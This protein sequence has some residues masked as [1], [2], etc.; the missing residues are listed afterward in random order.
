MSL[1]GNN[2]R[3]LAIYYC[4][5]HICLKEVYGHRSKEAMLFFRLLLALFAGT[6]ICPAHAQQT[7][8][9]EELALSYGKAASIS[10]ATGSQQT[11][12][13][14]PAVATV[15]TSEDIAAMGA[16]DLD[17]VLETVPGIH[18]N[19]SANNYSPLYVVRG[20]FSQ[21]SPQVLVL[22]NGLPITTLYQG[23]KGN[24]WGGYP[25]E[26]IARIEIIR[27][28]GSALYGSDAF[29]G[30]INIITKSAAE[31]AGTDIGV[32][33]GSFA[34]RDAWIQHGSSIG[35]TKVAAYLRIGQTAG[36]R[37]II[38]ADA[39]SRND[40]LFGTKVSLAPGP[41]NVGREAVDAGLDVRRGQWEA[42]LGYKLRD[43]LGTGAGIASALDPTGK[44]RSE[45]I[46][47]SLSWSDHH[48]I[49]D[50]SA[51]F[52]VSTLQYKQQIPV[53]FRLLPPGATLP[54]GTFQDGM[55]A[56][57]DTWER[58]VRVSAFAEHT[59]VSKHVIRFGVGHEDMNM[60]RTRETRNF[61]YT[62]SGTPIP[63]AAVVD[64]SES[65]PFLFPHR[66]KLDFLYVQD[67]WDIAQDWTL[68]SGVRRDRYSDF[69]ATTNPRIALVWDAAVDITAKLMFGRAFRAPSYIE[70]YGITNPVAIGN[71]NLVPEKIGTLESSVSWHPRYDTQLNLSMYRY[72]MKDIIRTVP[73]AVPG[74]GATYANT[75]GQ[76]GYGFELEGAWA[77]TR[78]LRL[79]A[80]YA[81]QRSM[82]G[83]NLDAGYAPRR[84]V[85]ARADWSINSGYIAGL[86]FNHIGGRHRAPGDARPAVK[87]YNTVDLTLRKVGQK[88][89]WDLT[90][91]VRNLLNADVREPSLAP[92]LAIPNDLP[93]APRSV[94]LHIVYK[95]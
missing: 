66:R 90:A 74:T 19:R 23:N 41:V 78:A 36:F 10:I 67:I 72:Q 30:V 62:S 75:A 2:N 22:Q 25:I 92:G 68:T 71:P 87:D 12:R 80:N 4:L 73:N 21:F 42:R 86:L 43:K 15:I 3:L 31:I 50:W 89:G 24:L 93:M 47:T 81:W 7:N 54:T 33:F 37:S 6:L 28:P 85:A 26:H 5:R 95:M 69:G 59:G 40:A 44:Q 34:S 82:D 56:G 49:Q 32:R 14:A 8:D 11:I 13:Q 88:K 57:P 53:D 20:I 52:S 27:G 61:T 18:V 39:Q 60:Y 91:S 46:T 58:H 64:F 63:Q 94:W 65:N 55:I 48:S 9:E 84:Q 38:T 35:G 45:R 77:A 70:F 16:I 83:S 29:S 51:G 76:K 17:E 79:N 1:P